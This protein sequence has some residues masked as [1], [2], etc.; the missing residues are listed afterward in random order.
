MALLET[1]INVI[2]EENENLKSMLKRMISSYDDLQKQIRYQEEK[3]HQTRTDRSQRFSPA[4]Q[5]EENFNFRILSAGS[6]NVD[7]GDSVSHQS[8][9]SSD[10]HERVREKDERNTGFMDDQ[11]LT[12]NRREITSLQLDQFQNGM[13]NSS[14]DESPNKKHQALS[15]GGGEQTVAAPKRVVCMR[16]T[17]EA[18]VV[19]IELLLFM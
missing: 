4:R 8:N 10:S 16:T 5:I 6:V 11:Q 7:S 3:Q 12:S 17:S 2:K 13:L 19:I 14:M 9:E 1:H 15:Q 18:S